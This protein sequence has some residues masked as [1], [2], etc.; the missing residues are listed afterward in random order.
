[1]GLDN[2]LEVS[3]GF[4]LGAFERCV[5]EENLERL[6]QWWKLCS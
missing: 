1:M 6:F 3:M 4:L 5:K 2:L